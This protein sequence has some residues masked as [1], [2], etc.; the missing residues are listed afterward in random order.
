MCM[1][2]PIANAN[3]GRYID[4]HGIHIGLSWIASGPYLIA[5]WCGGGQ[6]GCVRENLLQVTLHAKCVRLG[7]K[8]HNSW[9]QGRPIGS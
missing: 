5:S 9:L 7:C 8:T 2:T 6:G 1:Y 3:R 4:P